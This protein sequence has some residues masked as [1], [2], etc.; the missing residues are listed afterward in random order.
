M[1]VSNTQMGD[2]LQYSGDATAIGSQYAQLQA[3]L[4]QT[5]AAN[6]VTLTVA[7]S[8][9]L[10]NGVAFSQPYLS[11]VQQDFSALETSMSFADPTVVADDVNAWVS[12]ETDQ[13]IPSILA[14][15]DV[16]AQKSI[17]FLVGVFKVGA[18]FTPPTPIVFDVDRPF[19]F[20]IRDRNTGSILFVGSVTN[21]NLN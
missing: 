16:S 8:L 4:T 7:N 13:L 21:P 10:N 19:L 3:S 14:P 5:A 15:S 18:V 11:Q 17:A 12:Q 9:W 20:F 2:V 1:V 6:G